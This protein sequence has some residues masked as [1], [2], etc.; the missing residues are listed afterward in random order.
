[1]YVVSAYIALIVIGGII[2]FFIKGM[3]K[4]VKFAKVKA[5]SVMLDLSEWVTATIFDNYKISI[6]STLLSNGNYFYSKRKDY[7]I[8]ISR[9]DHTT[10]G[11]EETI[12]KYLRSVYVNESQIRK[13]SEITSF[14]ING[15]QAKYYVA[16]CKNSMWTLAVYDCAGAYLSL[17]I[18]AYNETFEAVTQQIMNSFNK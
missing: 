1:M 2:F 10:S 7:S 18:N 9:H 11:Q 3:V 16:K 13:E 15:I 14:C 17:A 6:P 12:L 4:G 5:D 8:Q